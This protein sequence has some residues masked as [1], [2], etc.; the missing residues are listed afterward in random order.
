ISGGAGVQ[1]PYVYE[2]KNR[3]TEH[4]DVFVNAGNQRAMRAPG[5]PQRCIV[6]EAAMDDLADKLGLD[7]LEMRLKNLAENDPVATPE[8]GKTFNR[9][10]IYRQQ[11]AMGAE[12]IG[13]KQN[14]K[15]RGQNG[16]G[17]VKRGLGMALHQW[18]GGGAPDKKVSCS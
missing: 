18:G 12:L 9:S 2:V 5:H 17:P 10:E 4:T 6:M 13:W 3:R 11:V 14:R 1:L 8:R 7:P 16:Q 15:P